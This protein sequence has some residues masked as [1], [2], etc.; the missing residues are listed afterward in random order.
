MSREL[1]L[2]NAGILK[3]GAKILD[4]YFAL[5]K[6]GNPVTFSHDSQKHP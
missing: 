6:V 2:E 3:M 4:P 1:I 5:T